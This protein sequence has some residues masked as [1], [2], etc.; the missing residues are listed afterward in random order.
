MFKK[1]CF[2]TTRINLNIY[3]PWKRKG[4]KY[5]VFQVENNQANERTADQKDYWSRIIKKLKDHNSPS[6]SD[7]YIKP[8]C[9]SPTWFEYIFQN[10]EV[11]WDKHKLPR[12]FF[13]SYQVKTVISKFMG[14]LAK[15]VSSDI[16]YYK[17]TIQT[18]VTKIKN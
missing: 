1:P 3:F 11:S 8:F 6:G 4:G 15:R 9:M 14:M 18:Y 17:T 10:F 5:L 12:F 13:S 2:S 7:C 16:L